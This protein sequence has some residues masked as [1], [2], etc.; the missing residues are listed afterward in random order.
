MGTSL[1]LPQCE[2][3]C[4]AVM[5]CPGYLSQA[6]AGLANL[7]HVLSPRIWGNDTALLDDVQSQRLWPAGDRR[8]GACG[9]KV[10]LVAHCVGIAY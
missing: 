8:D 5:A 4:A 3:T 1:L 10:W 7:H 2:T 6:L 9:S